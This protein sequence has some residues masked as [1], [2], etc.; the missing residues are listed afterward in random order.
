MKVDE[1][2]WR[3][4]GQMKVNEGGSRLMGLDKG[5]SGKPMKVDES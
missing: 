4:M 2:E 5:K 3:L 1:A